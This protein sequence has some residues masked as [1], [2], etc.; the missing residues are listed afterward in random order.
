[1]S[2]FSNLYKSVNFVHGKLYGMGSRRVVSCLLKKSTCMSSSLLEWELR[3]E[4]F[5]GGGDW[6]RRV[7]LVILLFQPNFSNFL[8]LFQFVIFGP[9]GVCFGPLG[10]LFKFK[11][12]FYS[13]NNIL[14]SVSQ[15]LLDSE[16]L[17]SQVCRLQTCLFSI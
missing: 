14:E 6:C 13:F 8:F 12:N 2:A 17:F 7:S 16:T 3:V 4:F 15:F 11:F 1:M 10:F 5:R 9:L